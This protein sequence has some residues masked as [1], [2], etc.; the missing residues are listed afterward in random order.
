MIFLLAG[1]QLR[2][3][4]II[5]GPYSPKMRFLKVYSNYV[6]PRIGIVLKRK[7]R[8]KFF[9]PTQI[10]I[11]TSLHRMRNCALMVQTNS[12]IVNYIF[13]VLYPQKIM[14]QALCIN[15]LGTW[16]QG[17]WV[18]GSVPCTQVPCSKVP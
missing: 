13:L 15:N 5:H 10:Q 14:F 11:V 2:S 12:T 18:H 1:N 6:R 16:V 4:A 3:D 17:T 7:F 9:Q 8:K